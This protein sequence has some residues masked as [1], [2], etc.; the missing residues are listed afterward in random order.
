M[1]TRWD[2]AINE[3]LYS[4][5]DMVHARLKYDYSYSSMI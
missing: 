4:T 2:K 3:V 5:V 1:L